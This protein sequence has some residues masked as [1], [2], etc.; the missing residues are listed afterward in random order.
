MFSPRRISSK[1]ARIGRLTCWWI[2][3]SRATCTP[4]PICSSSPSAFSSSSSPSS[5]FFSEILR[6][7]ETIFLFV[8]IQIGETGEFPPSHF[9]CYH[10]RQVA[11]DCRDLHFRCPRQWPRFHHDSFFQVRMFWGS[12]DFV[13]ERRSTSTRPCRE[14]KWLLSFPP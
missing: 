6:S 13:A 9:C 4:S 1:S 2:A 7:E 12:V 14:R 3:W 5:C 11:S 8:W 10:E